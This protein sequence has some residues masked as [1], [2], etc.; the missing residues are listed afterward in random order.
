MIKFKNEFRN[1][2][3]NKFRMIILYYCDK[4]I[5]DRLRNKALIPIYAQIIDVVENDIDD[6]Y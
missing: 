3:M 6:N 4:K 2:H 5:Y 1:Q